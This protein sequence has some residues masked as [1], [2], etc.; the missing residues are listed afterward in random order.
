M[1]RCG[2]FVKRG[3]AKFAKKIQ[4]FGRICDGKG[5]ARGKG[6]ECAAMRRKIFGKAR[7]AVILFCFPFF[8]NRIFFPVLFHGTKHDGIFKTIDFFQ[9][10]RAFSFARTKNPLCPC[11]ICSRESIVAKWAVHRLFD[12]LTPDDFKAVAIKQFVCVQK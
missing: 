3:G 9:A 7:R 4:N 1:A 6:A 11:C 12:I 8:G 5:V 10:G 2:G